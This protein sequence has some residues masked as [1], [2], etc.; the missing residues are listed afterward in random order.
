[1]YVCMYGCMYVRVAHES[2]VKYKCL[3]NV[4]PQGRP[5][6]TRYDYY[7]CQFWSESD[8][9]LR[10]RHCELWSA[11]YWLTKNLHCHLGFCCLC[12][13]IIFA[14]SADTMVRTKTRSSPSVWLLGKPDKNILGSGLSTNGAVIKK[15][16]FHL[17]AKKLE[18]I[19][20]AELTIDA[21][22]AI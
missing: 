8:D 10:S 1:M 6:S 17:E 12:S 4:A 16:M 20:G 14:L 13:K 18:I 19:K 5:R 11:A 15:I 21:T 9:I 7:M 3:K 22:L 2:M